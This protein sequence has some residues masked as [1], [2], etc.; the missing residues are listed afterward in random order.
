MEQ[1]ERL[2]NEEE[3]EFY[4]DNEEEGEH[5]QEDDSEELQ[6]QSPESFNNKKRNQGPAQQM[7]NQFQ[8][9]Q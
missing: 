5:Y 1:E 7:Q 3:Q 4:D 6:Y 9:P 2:E 8:L